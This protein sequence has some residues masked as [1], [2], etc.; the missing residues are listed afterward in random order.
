M[1]PTDVDILRIL[2]A[3]GRASLQTIADRIG[4]RRPSVHARVKRLEED[5]VI[6][7]YAAKLDPPSVGA[8]LLALV[9]LRVAHG[10]GQDCLASCGRVADGLRKL[11]QVLEFHTMAGDDD[12]LL[13]VRVRDVAELEEIVMRE[14]S[15][16][17]GVERVRTSIVLST[18]F[19]RPLTPSPPP[20]APPRARP[21]R[22][23]R[24]GSPAR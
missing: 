16:L 2:A 4:L 13:K 20:R 1:D 14:V 23:R 3:D 15:G 21:S 12:V 6:R 17:A 19:E 5:G 11:P 18:Q 24:S 9:F 22:G 10:K 8:G 7:G